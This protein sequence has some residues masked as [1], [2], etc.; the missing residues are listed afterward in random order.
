MARRSRGVPQVMAYC[1][2]SPSS[3]RCAAS[4]SS[5]GGGKLGMPWARLMPSYWLFTRVISRMTDSVNPC[6][7]CEMPIIARSPSRE[8][9]VPLD[10]IPRDALRLQPGHASLEAVLRALQLEHDPA[11]VGPHLSAADVGKQIE[12]LD[13]EREDT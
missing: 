6:T 4:P 1:G 9:P 3:A 7:R 13:A 8:P 10:G 11:V 2:K 5:R 12:V